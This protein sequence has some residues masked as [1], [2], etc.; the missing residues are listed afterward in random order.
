MD[1]SIT[2]ECVRELGLLAV[3]RGPSLDLTIQMVD[4][5]VVGGVKGIEIAYSTPQAEF[6]LAELVKK[7]VD[8]VLLGMGTLT[9]ADQAVKCKS[10]RCKIF[11]KPCLY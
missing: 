8:Q 2:L 11:S 10:S 5:L 6:V 4:A 3:I 9:K 1:K 7:Y